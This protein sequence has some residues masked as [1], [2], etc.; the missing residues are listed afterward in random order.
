MATCCPVIEL[1]QYT[2]HTGQRDVLIDLFEREFIE[3]QEALGISVIGQFRDRD[4]PNRFVWLRGFPSMAARGDAL[5][6]FYGGT[7][8]QAHRDA[9]NATMLDSD[10][11]LLLRP[12]PG[13]SGFVLPERSDDRISEYRAAESVVVATIHYLDEDAAADFVRFFAAAMMPT[14]VAAGGT[15]LAT[16]ETESARNNFPRL[17]V[18]EGEHVFVW[19]CGF[20]DVAA[21]ARFDTALRRSAD[22]RAAASPEL[23]RQFMRKAERLTLLP[24]RRSLLRGPGPLT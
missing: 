10:N 4:D 18:R 21:H 24:T 9:A 17:P 19:L 12:A 23:L 2:L 7:V 6:A 13:G 8:W 1:R 3:S 14:V 11:V 16:L 20:P 22:W 15:I 5:A